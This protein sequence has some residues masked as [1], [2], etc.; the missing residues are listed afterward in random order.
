MKCRYCGG[1]RRFQIISSVSDGAWADC[2]CA[3]HYREDAEPAAILGELKLATEE[4]LRRALGQASL[5][6]LAIGHPALNDEPDAYLC[7]SMA[8]G[9]LIRIGEA[10]K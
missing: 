3:R 7:G 5:T 2:F 8:R 1:A 4:Q 9:A 10:L 6:L